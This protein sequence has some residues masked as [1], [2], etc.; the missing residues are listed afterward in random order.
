MK[1]WKEGRAAYNKVRKLDRI[2]QKGVPHS[3]LMDP[4]Y[5][6]WKVKQR[7]DKKGGKYN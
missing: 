5:L 4:I 2:K 3:H 6:N 7:T 1:M